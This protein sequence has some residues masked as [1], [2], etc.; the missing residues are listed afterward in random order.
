MNETNQFFKNKNM[1]I[2]FVLNQAKY[3][4]ELSEPDMSSKEDLNRP[5]IP[6]MEDLNRTC[7]II[8]GSEPDIPSME[9]LNQTCHQW[10][11]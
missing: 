6:S 8:G 3:L 2:K 10:R 7:C 5:D 1:D 4:S 11:I 9:D